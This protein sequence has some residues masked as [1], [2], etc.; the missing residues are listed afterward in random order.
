MSRGLQLR[1]A[2]SLTPL[3]YNDKLFETLTGDLKERLWPV[4]VMAWDSSQG[5]LRKWR[6]LPATSW[7][8]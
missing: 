5:G 8:M 2:K 7:N 3:E 6:R 1:G 4:M